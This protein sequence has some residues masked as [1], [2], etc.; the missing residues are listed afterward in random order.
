MQR[1]P[2]IP[3]STISAYDMNLLRCRKHLGTQ[4]RGLHAQRDDLGHE[5]AGA[6]QVMAIILSYCAGDDKEDGSGTGRLPKT[7]TLK[8]ACFPP[9]IATHRPLYPYSLKHLTSILPA[10]Y[11]IRLRLNVSS[12]DEITV[13]RTTLQLP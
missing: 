9:P 12:R 3:P 8:N 1:G 10:S 5:I 7:S 6:E 4:H 2:M 11:Q 13:R